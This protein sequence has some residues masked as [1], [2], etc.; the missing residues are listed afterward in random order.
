MLVGRT[1]SGKTVTWQ[2]LKKA[3]TR[4]NRDGEPGY[5]RAQV[6]SY[7]IFLLKVKTIN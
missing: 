2:I 5:Q 3:L 4:L 1:Q 6:F 7:I